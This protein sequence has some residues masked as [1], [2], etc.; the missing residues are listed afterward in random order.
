PPLGLSVA[1]REAEP[2]SAAHRSGRERDRELR[3]LR[4]MRRGRARRRALP[5]VLPRRGGAEPDRVGSL[6]ASRPPCG[7]R[8]AR[9]ARGRG[10]SDAR[11]ITLMIA[12]LGGEGGGVLTDWIVSA[13]ESVGYP[14]Q[15]TSIPGVAQR[16][17]ATTYYVEIFPVHHSELGG[18]RP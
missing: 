16:T 4:A 9:A 11:P 13:A 17:G 10:V 5:V 2:R 6:H 3:R 8:P 7:H 14:V 18:K 12:A 15:S 1:H